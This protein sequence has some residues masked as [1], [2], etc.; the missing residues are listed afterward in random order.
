[1]AGNINSNIPTAVIHDTQT[2][3]QIVSVEGTIYGGARAM[4]CHNVGAGAGTFDGIVVSPGEVINYPFCGTTYGP[5]NYNGA[6]TAL[7]IFVFR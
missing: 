3:A 2:E 6:G 4:S 1:M 7:K 5:I